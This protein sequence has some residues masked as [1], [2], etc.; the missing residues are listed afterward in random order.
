MENVDR[1]PRSAAI[2]RSMIEL[3]HSLNLQVTAEGIERSEQLRFLHGCGDV[4]VQGY[5]LARPM[6]ADHVVAACTTLPEKLQQ[7]L[8]EMPDS[9]TPRNVSHLPR[10]TL[11]RS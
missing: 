3:C 6:V 5:L 10:R 11:P 1:N 8:A 7:H 4:D 9:R 2:T